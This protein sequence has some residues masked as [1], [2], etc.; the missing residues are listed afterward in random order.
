[1]FHLESEYTLKD[2]LA[3]EIRPKGSFCKTVSFTCSWE[4]HCFTARNILRFSRYRQTKWVVVDSG[5]KMRDS[6]KKD[7]R[8]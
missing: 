5:K 2:A 4:E 1:M 8:H 6:S 3:Q 7:K